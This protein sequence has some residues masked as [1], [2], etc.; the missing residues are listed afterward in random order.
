[1]R[2]LARLL[3]GVVLVG[4]AGLTGW[5]ALTIARDP[6]LRPFVE[7]TADQI[8]AATDRDM[9]RQATPERLSDRIDARLAEDTRNWVALRALMDEARL[10]KLRLR[11]ATEA[12]YTAAWDEDSGLLTT[13][14]D[15]AACAY[16]PAV[17]TL[18]NLMICQVP[19]ALTP[20]GD[21]AGV[22]RAGVAW[23][24]GGEVD[25]IDLGLSILGLGATGLVLATGGTSATVKAGAAT[26]RM[27]RRMG[28]MSPRLTAMAADAV[29]RGVDWTALPAVRSADDLARA[30]RTEA[31]APLVATAQDINRLRAAT[32]IPEALHLLPLIEDAADARRLARA[33][34][35]LGPRLVARAEVLGKARLLRATLRVGDTA[36]ALISGMVGLLLALAQVAGGWLQTGMLRAL[37][38]LAR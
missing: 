24:T 19:I 2:R 6:L 36:L 23:G 14:T 9:A 29:R 18:S 32:G 31:F 1:M 22:A 25:K 17:C 26:A 3:L 5:A 20:V 13:V 15:C 7:T 33:G 8:V 37:R 28:L 12:A 35:A 4:S 34:E 10:R 27:A 38:R 21:L 16:D 30:V 11:P